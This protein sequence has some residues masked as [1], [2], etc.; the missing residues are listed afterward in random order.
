M[1]SLPPLV[2]TTLMD[3]ASLLDRADAKEPTQLQEIVD[4]LKDQLQKELN[5]RIEVLKKEHQKE[6]F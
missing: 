6:V 3:S 2:E 4:S 5:E 1:T